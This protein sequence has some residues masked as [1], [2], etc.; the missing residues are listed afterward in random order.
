MRTGA[1][2]QLSR[3]MQTVAQ[4]QIQMQIQLQMEIQIQIQLQLCQCVANI[5]NMPYRTPE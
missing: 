4:M 2:V 1:Y 5:Y 3:K